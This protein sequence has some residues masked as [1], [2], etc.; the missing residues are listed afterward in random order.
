VEIKL[1]DLGCLQTAGGFVSCANDIGLKTTRSLELPRSSLVH[2]AG[3]RIQYYAEL[4]W[5]TN[6]RVL[7]AD[8]RC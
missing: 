3:D 1:A 5:I 7:V 8:I 4:T 6:E 2:K